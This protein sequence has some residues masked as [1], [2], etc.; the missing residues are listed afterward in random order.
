MNEIVQRTNPLLT[1]PDDPLHNTVSGGAADSEVN[2]DEALAIR[3]RM[4]AE[5]LAKLPEGLHDP[6][7]ENVAIMESLK[8]RVK[9]GDMHAY[10]ME[11]PCIR[12]LVVS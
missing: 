6:L 12:L 1:L 7:M 5:Y 10:G 3:E 4:Y 2:V 8:K 9:V 11:K